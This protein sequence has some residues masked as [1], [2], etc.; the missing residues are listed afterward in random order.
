MNVVGHSSMGS[1]RILRFGHGFDGWDGI[2]GCEGLDPTVLNDV[3]DVT[4]VLVGGMSVW[5]IWVMSKRVDTPSMVLGGSWSHSIEY[6]TMASSS[7]WRLDSLS[8]GIVVSEGYMVGREV[9]AEESGGD[10]KVE[11]KIHLSRLNKSVFSSK[12]LR[13][14]PQ[15]N[16]L[17]SSYGIRLILSCIA[18]SS[19]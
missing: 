17:D 7:V 5:G 9:V 14:I 13:N 8:G 18:T 10:I 12:Y 16:R 6:S 11:W 4:E 19:N 3:Y 1:S 2:V 15:S